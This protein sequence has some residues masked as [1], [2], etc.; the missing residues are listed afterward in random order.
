MT[1]RTLLLSTLLFLSFSG[2]RAQ[3]E[4]IEAVMY[5]NSTVV[6]D[7]LNE[8]N[9]KYEALKHNLYRITL[10]DKFK[11]SLLIDDGDMILRT[12]FSDMEPSLNRVNDFNASFRWGR[13]Y[14]DKDGDLTYAAELSFTGGIAEKGIHIFINTYGSL[15]E[16]VVE[17]LKVD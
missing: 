9:I 2:L 4:T 10:K 14:F 13:V 16:T 8:K 17:R 7:I 5:L 1:I 15:L 11:V 12:Y 6:E 3:T